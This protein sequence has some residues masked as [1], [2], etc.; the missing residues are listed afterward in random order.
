VKSWAAGAAAGSDA[1]GSEK[2]VGIEQDRNGAV[3]H[4]LDGH[5]RLKHAGGHAHFQSFKRTDEF[6]VTGFALIGWRGPEKTGPALAAGVAIKSELG[7]GEDGAADIEQRAVHFALLVVE[8]SEVHDFFRHRHRSFGSVVAA[9]SDQHDESAADFAGHVAIDLNPRAGHSLNYGSHR[10][11]STCSDNVGDDGA[12]AVLTGEPAFD[13]TACENAMGDAI[14]N[15]PQSKRWLTRGVLG[16]GLASLFSDWGHE[17]ATSILPAFLASLG[18]PAAA[19]GVIEGVS[20]GL[21][22]F[23]K[24]AGGFVADQPRWRKPTGIAGYFA[25]AITT[26]AYALAHTWP[27]V[28]ALR[29]IGWMGRGSRGPSRDT[30]LAEY[31]APGQIGRAFGFERAMD[32]VGAVLGPLCATALLGAL[33]IRG[34]LKWTLL[35]GLAAALAFAFLVPASRKAEGQ[36][37]SA[38]AK[39]SERFAR[40][41]KG[42]WRYLTGVF[43]HGIGDFAPTLLILRASQILAPQWGTGRAAAISVGLYTFHN[44]VDAAASYPAGALGDRM[45]KRGLLATGYVIGVVS[46]CGFI[47]AP[48]EISVLAILFG[49]AGIHHAFEQSLEKSAA[50]EFIASDVRG[51][52]FGVLATANGLGDLVSSVVVGA[53]WSAVSPAAG[54]VYAAAFAML[55]AAVVYFSG[56]SRTAGG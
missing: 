26:C 5:V 14:A 46:Y 27:A 53:L 40:L 48:A 34:V 3:V 44:F 56:E 36:G 4:Q 33:G 16:V 19:L 51:T 54:F 8:D 45:G 29:A 32:T 41:P 23:A 24:L 9:D 35:P 11:D 28:L 31:V 43:A 13:Q 7:D 42:Y 22:S 6:F 2:F 12:P 25:T 49:L 30:L 37:S 21:S 1:P 20:D 55:G 39:F 47:F 17:A 18:A 10:S 38:H 52:G 15:D 50:A